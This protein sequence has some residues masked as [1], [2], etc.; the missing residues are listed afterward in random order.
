[1][2][3]RRLVP[4]VCLGFALAACSSP[5]RAAGDT[6]GGDD[7]GSATDPTS[8]PKTDGA[9]AGAAVCQPAP[10]STCGATTQC[11]CAADQTC[12]VQDEHT[13][14]ASCVPAGAAALGG[15][16]NTTS[17]CAQGLTC[18]YGV[19]RPYCAQ[20]RTYC[21]AK[22][23]QL[24]VEVKAS[25]HT[26]VPG[27]NVCTIACDPRRPQAFCG[28]DTCVWF[29]SYYAPIRGV[30]DCGPAG[31]NGDAQACSKASDCQA[32]FACN[33]HPTRGQECEPWCR[34]GGSDCPSGET[35]VD[36]FKDDAPVVGGVHEGLCQRP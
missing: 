3:A 12:D 26:I 22:G 8:T 9:D 23:T 14:A 19:C 6:T 7:V 16:C 33:M 32:G 34:I 24:C 20:A 25:D 31:P 21:T 36:V 11:G 28:T 29:A 13:G 35:C 1:M 5:Y 15:T 17:D 4:L 18:L 27:M 2:S 10:Q 30:S